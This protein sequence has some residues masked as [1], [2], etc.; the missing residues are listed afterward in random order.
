MTFAS[1]LATIISDVVREQGY[2]VNNPLP[3]PLY[4]FIDAVQKKAGAVR[5]RAQPVKDVDA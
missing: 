1:D 3:D 2:S 4:R 5:E